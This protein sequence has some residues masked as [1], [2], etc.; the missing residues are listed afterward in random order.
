MIRST[1]YFILVFFVV[2][3][4][5]PIV[6][7]ILSNFNDAIQDAPMMPT[8]AK[9]SIQTQTD[10]FGTI[11]D[12]TVLICFFAVAAALIG[13]AWILPTNPVV[14]FASMIVV[15][16]LAILA[17]FLANAWE[18]IT[19]GSGAYAASA[20]SFTIADFLMSHYLHFT[21]ALGFLILIVFYAKPNQEGV[22]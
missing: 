14:V 16:L 20:A 5:L 12:Y 9:S 4:S 1:V 11:W 19:T 7:L 6:F 2:V 21:V 13:I 3:L 15:V 18:E 17:G 8:T 10:K 22:F